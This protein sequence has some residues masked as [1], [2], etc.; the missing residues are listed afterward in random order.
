LRG[1]K[2]RFSRIEARLVRMGANGMLK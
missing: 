2:R 1:L